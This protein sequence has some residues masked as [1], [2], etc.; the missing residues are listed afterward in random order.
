MKDS[1]IFQVAKVIAPSCVS[2]QELFDAT[3]EFNKNLFQTF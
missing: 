3:S 2:R 1:D